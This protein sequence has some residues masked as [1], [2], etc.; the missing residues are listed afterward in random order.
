MKIQGIIKFHDKKNAKHSLAELG[1]IPE[2]QTRKFR[3]KNIQSGN[4]YAKKSC[5]ILLYY[6]I[7][8]GLVS[9]LYASCESPQEEITNSKRTDDRIQSCSA[10]RNHTPWIKMT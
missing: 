9:S 1:L 8:L 6:K 5:M 3:V 4:K 10:Y 2:G 7:V